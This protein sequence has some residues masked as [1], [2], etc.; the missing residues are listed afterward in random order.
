MYATTQTGSADELVTAYAPLVKRIA[1]HLIARL[2]SSVAVDDLIQAG[3][4]GLLDASRQYDPSQGARF[5]TYARIRIRGAMLDELRRND[6]APKSVHRKARELETAMA[7]IENATGRDARDA[8]VAQEMGISLDDYYQILQDANSCAV[9][10]FDDIG[11]DENSIGDGQNEYRGEPLSGMLQEQ[12]NK[13][14]ADAI[15]SLPERERMVISFYYDNE[16]NLRE[17]GDVLGVSESRISQ[18][19]SQAHMRLRARMQELTGT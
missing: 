13:R 17:I 14:L 18:L 5:E 8:E 15:A 7:R 6:W 16:L 19:M 12:F 11:L 4:L 3:M 1:Y 10:N 2:P 9:L